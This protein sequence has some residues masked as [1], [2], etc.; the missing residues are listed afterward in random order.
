MMRLF[1]VCGL[2]LLVSGCA[3]V[4]P[5]K[6]REHLLPAQGLGLNGAPAPEIAWYVHTKMSLGPNA[7]KGSMAGT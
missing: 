6:P 7:I 2:A 4:P 3:L 5:A 1:A